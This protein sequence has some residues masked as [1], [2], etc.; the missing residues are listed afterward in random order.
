MKTEGQTFPFLVQA[1]GTA[2]TVDAVTTQLTRVPITTQDIVGGN[3]VLHTPTRRSLMFNPGDTTEA[4]MVAQRKYAYYRLR[5]LTA[6]PAR[7]PC[8]GRTIQPWDQS[9]RQYNLFHPQG[10]TYRLLM[11]TSGPQG[12]L[13]R[14]VMRILLLLPVMRHT[15]L[16]MASTTPLTLGPTA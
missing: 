6:H 12:I 2:A 4:C 14:K 15:H 8:H 3:T 16:Q 10:R 11:G 9:P 13:A 1:R 7:A 5:R